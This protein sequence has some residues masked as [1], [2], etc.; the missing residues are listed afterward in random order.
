[1]KK[2]MLAFALAAAAT[3]A[4]AVPASAGISTSPG[5]PRRGV[6]VDQEMEHGRSIP[7]VRR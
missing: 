2:K 6:V 7:T 4:M 1:M 3:V 5:G